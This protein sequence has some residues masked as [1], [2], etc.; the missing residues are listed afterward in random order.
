MK[1]H[2]YVKK[3]MEFARTHNIPKGRLSEIAVIHDDW[4]GV[5]KG[6]RCNC[7]PDVKLVK[8]HARSDQHKYN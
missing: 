7:D 2:N 4:C 5:F 8:V 6:K 1:E 3:V